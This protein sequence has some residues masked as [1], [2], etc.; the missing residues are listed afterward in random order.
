MSLTAITNKAMVAPSSRN[1]GKRTAS[2]A[3]DRDPKRRRCVTRTIT[4]ADDKE[5]IPP[6]VD[7]PV[8]FIDELVML[9]HGQSEAP[10]A[11]TVP[12]ATTTAPRASAVTMAAL[13]SMPISSTSSTESPTASASLTI[14]ASSAPMTTASSTP[15]VATSTAHTTPSTDIAPLTLIATVETQATSNDLP[16]NA[17]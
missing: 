13:F 11:T 6:W 7:Q 5:N 9:V 14:A 17:E 2:T 1:R 12:V 3:L 16:S 4:F 8:V 10:E 15:A